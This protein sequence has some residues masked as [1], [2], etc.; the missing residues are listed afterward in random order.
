[1]LVRGNT[2][3]DGVNLS[4]SIGEF[5]YYGFIVQRLN[6]RFDMEKYLAY[7]WQQEG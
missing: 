2:N 6:K 7:I 1:M 4:L 5:P 3:C